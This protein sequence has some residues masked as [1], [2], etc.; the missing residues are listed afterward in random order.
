MTLNEFFKKLSADPD[1]LQFEDTMAAI[2]HRFDFT[3]S[4]FT[5]GDVVNNKGEN[6]GSCKVFAFAKLEKLTEKQT[7]YCFGQYYREVVEHPDLNS[8]R[9]IRAFMKNGWQ[10]VDLPDG[11]LTLKTN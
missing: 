4:A 3:E 8:H 5:N 6:S 9:N 11:V 1:G 2:D 7:L 10:G